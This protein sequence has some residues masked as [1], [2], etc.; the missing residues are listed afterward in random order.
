MN[1]DNDNLQVRFMKDDEVIMTLDNTMT[2][3]TEHFSVTKRYLFL[4][5]DTTEL[6]SDVQSSHSL[7]IVGMICLPFSVKC[8]PRALR[9]SEQAQEL[10]P[11]EHLLHC[12][13]SN[14]KTTG[15]TNNACHTPKRMTR[16]IVLKKERNK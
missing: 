15:S 16:S 10:A 12:P 3:T 5:I 13:L 2:H 9:F 14:D 11:H 1:N 8:F 7:K 4:S 6:L